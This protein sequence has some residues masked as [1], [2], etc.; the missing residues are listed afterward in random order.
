MPFE[1]Y[2]ELYTTIQDACAGQYDLDNFNKVLHRHK[3][4]LQ[5]PRERPPNSQS[6]SIVKSGK[7]KLQESKPEVKLET[8]YIEFA[9]QIS[10]R[11]HL[12]EVRARYPD[13]SS[14]LPR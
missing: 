4:A 2:Q 13:T 10:D 5:D 9:L 8:P 11:L 3:A 12:D 1:D 6:R 14:G 7:V